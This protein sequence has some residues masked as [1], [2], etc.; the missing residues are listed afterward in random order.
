MKL[1]DI[2]TANNEG[3]LYYNILFHDKNILRL[4]NHLWPPLAMPQPT[5]ALKKYTFYFQRPYTWFVKKCEY[6]VSNFSDIFWKYL[7]NLYQNHRFKVFKDFSKDWTFFQQAVEKP[8]HLRFEK[9]AEAKK[10]L[11]KFSNCFRNKTWLTLLFKCLS[12]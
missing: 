4:F 3:Y 1:T 8:R 10:S 12:F 6:N 11:S 7:N 9:K 2:S 5:L